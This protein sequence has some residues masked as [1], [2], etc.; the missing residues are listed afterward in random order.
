MTKNTDLLA[1]LAQTAAK[2]NAGAEPLKRSIEKKHREVR[3]AKAPATESKPRAVSMYR[4]PDDDRL[5]LHL[6]GEMAQRGVRVNESQILRA[7]LRA[8]DAL[9]P[10]EI[11]EL[12]RDAASGK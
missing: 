12:I 8:L 6:V 3:K 1:K 11:A 7:A 5:I 2:G 4:Y 10:D 9:A